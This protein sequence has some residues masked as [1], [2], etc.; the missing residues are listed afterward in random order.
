VWGKPRNEYSASLL[1]PSLH[2][3]SQLPCYSCDRTNHTLPNEWWVHCWTR[4]PAANVSIGTLTQHLQSTVGDT[5]LLALLLRFVIRIVRATRVQLVRMKH[6]P[7]ILLL[8]PLRPTSNSHSASAHHNLNSETT[9]NGNVCCC[10]CC[11]CCFCIQLPKGCSSRRSVFVFSH[12][13]LVSI[14]H[15]YAASSASSS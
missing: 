7:V 5:I 11:C 12:Y 9:L 14:L 4:I 8:R 13:I 3:Y 15:R 10:C 2:Q 6:S 1:F